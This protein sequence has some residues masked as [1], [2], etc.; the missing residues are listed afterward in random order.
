MI[1]ESFNPAL[2]SICLKIVSYCPL[3]IILPVL[4]PKMFSVGILSIRC[5]K[6][7]KIDSETITERIE[8]FVLGSDTETGD[9]NHGKLLNFE[10]LL[11]V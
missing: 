6:A 5:F 8:A 4:S 1:P 10:Y 2:A 9:L 7:L 11:D 3:C